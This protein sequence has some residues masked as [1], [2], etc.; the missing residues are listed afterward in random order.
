VKNGQAPNKRLQRTNFTVT[1][2]ALRG[3][4]AA[5]KICSL[6]RALCRQSKMRA[7]RKEARLIKES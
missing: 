5:S 3:K 4:T 7:S 1:I 2:F 6:S